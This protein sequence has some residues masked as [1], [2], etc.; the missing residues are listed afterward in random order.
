M[1]KKE[2]LKKYLE[3]L[4]KIYS[5]KSFSDFVN[6]I[7]SY[8]IR[9]GDYGKDISL[10]SKEVFNKIL[11]LIPESKA[12]FSY[13]EFYNFF[14]IN[15]TYKIYNDPT[16]KV[17]MDIPVFIDNF[18]K[19]ALSLSKFLIDNKIN[20]QIKLQKFCQNPLMEIKV[21]NE[22]DALKVSK[23]FANDVELKKEIKSR[24]MPFL[25]EDNLIGISYEFRPFNFKNFY[26]VYLIE[27]FSTLSEGSLID[28]QDFEFFLENRY[29]TE[30]KINIKR[31]IKALYSSLYTINHEENIY[32]MFKYNSDMNIGS[33]DFNNYDLKIDKNKMIYFVNKLDNRILSFGSE[34]FLNIVYSKFYDNYIKREEGLTFYS[35]FYNIYSELLSNNF[36][37]L[38]KLLNFSLT[39]DDYVYSL[40]ML[41]SS[42]YFA[43]KK[44]NFSLNDVY[45]LLKKVLLANYNI[46]V[47]YNIEEESSNESLKVTFPFSIEYGNKVIDLKDGSKTTIKEYFRINKVLDV[48][49][50]N[51]LIYMNNG[52]ILKG[53]DFLKNI[54]KY[55][56][57][58]DSFEELRKS[59]ISL[60]EFK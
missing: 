43:Y 4:Y 12:K 60:V 27:Y 1:N 42:M 49:P 18:E 9:I 3:K 24:V 56:N 38:N 22:I 26:Y 52:Q 48:I 45:Y 59:L 11:T 19:I 14:K 15:I 55:I 44:M 37:E 21:D 32:S 46:D 57:M 28:L 6:T 2:L 58:Y 54:Y 34:E 50:L 41:I 47:N 8:N 13:K 33:M 31:M 51:S 40:M 7:L 5:E 29:K 39:S 17:T 36:K 16:P 20:S 30:S 35:Y 53:E 23:F 10:I 25:P